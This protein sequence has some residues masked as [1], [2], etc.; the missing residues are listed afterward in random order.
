MSAA[1]HNHCH[2]YELRL[3]GASQVPGTLSLGKARLTQVL[4][5]GKS[6][7]QISDEMP[8]VI[9]IQC[10]TSPRLAN[11]LSDKNTSRSAL[12]GTGNVIISSSSSNY[13]GAGEG[14]T[15]DFLDAKQLIVLGD[16]T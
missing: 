2:S 8:P 12:S 15:T 13:R 6:T 16:S 14:S 10:A 4:R 11:L 1:K 3:A 9:G 7:R 5:P